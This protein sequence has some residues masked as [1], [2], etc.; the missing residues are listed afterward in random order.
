MSEYSGEE[1][2][3]K[4]AFKFVEPRV[5]AVEQP[6]LYRR[7]RG[8]DG[9]LVWP[10][11]LSS[12]ET[13][14]IKAWNLLASQNPK[15]SNLYD[16]IAK[17]IQEETGQRRTKIQIYHKLL[18]L[19]KMRADLRTIPCTGMPKQKKAKLEYR[20]IASPGVL[21]SIGLR[22]FT[23]SAK[24]QKTEQ[25]VDSLQQ[26]RPAETQNPILLIDLASASVSKGIGLADVV[27]TQAIQQPFLFINY[28]GAL[29]QAA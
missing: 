13:V 4:P 12:R 18:T 28:F 10:E 9:K 1:D 23:L 2:Y 26:D 27:E 11:N 6:T 16:F 22:D 17:Y 7:Y 25:T 24:P 19:K 14:L 3:P 21:N 15:H 29:Q 20:K 8:T 5:I